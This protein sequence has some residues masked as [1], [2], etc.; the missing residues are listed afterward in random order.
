MSYFLVLFL[1]I[2][3]PVLLSFDRKVAFYRLWKYIFPAILITAFLFIL[4]DILFTHLGVWSFNRQY[5]SGIYVFNLPV[6]EI[7]FFMVVPYAALFTY[8]VLRVYVQ[9]DYLGQYARFISLFLAVV[10]IPSGL[11]F[12]DRLYTSSNLI[13]CGLL[14][15]FFQFVLR[16]SWMGRFYL[17]FG[18]I[19]VPFVLVNGVLT[20]S[21]IDGE[22]VS[23]NNAENLGLRIMTIPAEDIFYGMSLIL[24]NTGFF[25]YFRKKNRLIHPLR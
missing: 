4:W 17:A 14:V 13:F 16:V 6:E 19:L 9:K 15:L 12:Y 7:L 8:E 22:I 18:V 1:A 2:V 21:W 11:I 23:Y 10:L 3:F 25:E 5:L 24:L 20:G